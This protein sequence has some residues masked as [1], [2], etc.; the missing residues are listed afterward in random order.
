M[1]FEIQTQGGNSAN[2]NYNPT[3]GNAAPPPGFPQVA[4]NMVVLV[5]KSFVVCGNYAADTGGSPCQ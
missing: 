5:R 2:Y 3:Y 1:G 4:G